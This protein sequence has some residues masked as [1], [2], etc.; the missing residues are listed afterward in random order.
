ML[1]MIRMLR[2]APRDVTDNA[3]ERGPGSEMEQQATLE[4]GG[5]QVVVD[6]A[7]SGV[8]KCRRR[9]QLNNHSLRVAEF[10]HDV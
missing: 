2:I 5:P 6:L 7:R 9:L 10:E 1:R 8:M 4:V 3:P